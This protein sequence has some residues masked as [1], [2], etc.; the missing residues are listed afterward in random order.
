ML[1]RF[2][3]APENNVRSKIACNE[4]ARYYNLYFVTVSFLGFLNNLWLFF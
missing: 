1:K 3:Q 2:C 4:D